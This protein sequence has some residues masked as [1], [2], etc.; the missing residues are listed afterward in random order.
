V[1]FVFAK[2]KRPESVSRTEGKKS[3]KL[4]GGSFKIDDVGGKLLNRKRAGR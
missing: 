4:F 2:K 1:L 3:L